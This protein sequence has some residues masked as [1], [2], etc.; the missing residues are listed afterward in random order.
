MPVY[1]I[2]SWRKV[3]LFYT[4]TPTD[5]SGIGKSLSPQAFGL[6]KIFVPVWHGVVEM[7]ILG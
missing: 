3:E 6:V 4:P 1:V 7:G 5:L 2:P